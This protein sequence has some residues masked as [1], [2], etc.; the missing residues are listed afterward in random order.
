MYGEVKNIRGCTYLACTGQLSRAHH[1]HRKNA[2]TPAQAR[3]CDSATTPSPCTPLRSNLQPKLSSAKETT[4]FHKR[5]WRSR[6][7]VA[8]QALSVHSPLCCPVGPIQFVYHLHKRVLM[9]LRLVLLAFI[10]GNSIWGSI[11]SNPYW[12]ELTGFRPES[13][14]GPADDLD[15]WVPRSFPLSY[16]DRCITEDPSG[17]SINTSVTIAQW[18]RARDLTNWVIRRSPVSFQTKTRELKSIG[19]WANRHSGKGSK[20]LFPVVSGNK[21]QQN[22]IKSIR[23]WPLW[24]S[25]STKFYFP[26]FSWVF[27]LTSVS[28]ILCAW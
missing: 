7:C 1:A 22:Q 16:G 20:L 14:R 11:C 3:L 12:F 6:S 23:S 26:T 25:S 2:H 19:I 27:L 8:K 13:N 5:P 21:S 15:D 28:K 10:A 18:R 17:P 9:G 4:R 24:R